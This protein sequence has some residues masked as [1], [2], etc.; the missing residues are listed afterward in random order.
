MAGTP[1]LVSDTYAC[2]EML[3]RGIEW[4]SELVFEYIVGIA[5]HEGTRFHVIKQMVDI[6]TIEDL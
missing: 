5:R 3:F 6:D 1:S 4:G 2:T